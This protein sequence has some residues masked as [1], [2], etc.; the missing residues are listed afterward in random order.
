MTVPSPA[1]RPG[2]RTNWPAS[3]PR[4]ACPRKRS[5]WTRTCP[6]HSGGRSP[7]GPSPGFRT[8]IL[9]LAENFFR[10]GLELIVDETVPVLRRRGLFRTEC[11]SATLR[12]N[13]G[14]PG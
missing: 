4:S 12:G 5:T 11:E 1:G 14:L 13:L 8:V 3:P 10:G 2:F 7:P 9:A 6:G